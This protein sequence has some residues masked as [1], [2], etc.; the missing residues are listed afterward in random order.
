MTT[1]I[2]LYNEVTHSFI[3][4]KLKQFYSKAKKHV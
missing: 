1:V 4:R 3:Y 2:N